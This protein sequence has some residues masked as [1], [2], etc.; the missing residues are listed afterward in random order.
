[1]YSEIDLA[2]ASWR[3]VSMHQLPVVRDDLSSLS[4]SRGLTVFDLTSEPKNF[5]RLE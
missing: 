5:K 2:L 1:M 3:F 4:L